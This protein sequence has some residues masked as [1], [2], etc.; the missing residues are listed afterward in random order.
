MLME[1]QWERI[2]PIRE[3]DKGL[4]FEFECGVTAFD[5]WLRESAHNAASRG[6]CAAHV[7]ID[8][9]GAPVAFFTLSATSINSDVVSNNHR[10]GMHGPI[11]ATLLGKMGVR[12]DLQGGGCGTCVLH[13]AMKYALQSARIVSSRLFV[14]DALTSDLVSWY[15]ARGLKKLPGSERRLVCKMSDVETICNAQMPG[16]FI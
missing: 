14:V 5:R 7:C 1:R 12:T 15:E 6:E 10:G 4:F 9:D 11:P 8:R 2:A 3:I 16:Y 13:H